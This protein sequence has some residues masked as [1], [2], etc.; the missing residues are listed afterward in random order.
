MSSLQSK[1]RLICK[2]LYILSPDFFCI[3]F[4]DCKDDNIEYM[5]VLEFIKEHLFAQQSADI[6]IL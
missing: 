2:D 5:K 6:D 1:I 4:W 3:L